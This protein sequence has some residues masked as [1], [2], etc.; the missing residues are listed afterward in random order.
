M[1]ELKQQLENQMAK[2]RA[3][4]P[5]FAQAMEELIAEARRFEQG[6][7]ALAVGGK[8]ADFELPD[9]R[10]G[11][12]SLAGLLA[13]GPV[14]VS[15]YRGGWCPYC[16]L[17]FRALQ[18]RLPEIQ[19]LGASLV[20]ISPQ[21]PDESLSQSERQGLEFPVLSDQDA[22]VA[23]QFGVAW[24]VPDLLLD[25][26]RNDRKLDLAKINNGNGSVLPI[27]ATFVLDRDGVV[28]WRFVDV[29]YRKRAEPD[30]VV[31]ALREL[32]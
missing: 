22:L 27:P 11:R 7:D 3:G 5:E 15:F 26:M 10:G 8:A 28:R 18:A 32:G 16:D 9:A 12:V 13:D 21:V 31:A 14:V 25:H 17:Q 29:D 2:T 24:K 20:G 6:A 30:D 4:K 23:A 19:A 1:N